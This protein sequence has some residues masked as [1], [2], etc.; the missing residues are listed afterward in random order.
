[1]VKISGAVSHCSGALITRRHVLTAAHCFCKGETPMLDCPVE[2]VG[3][4]KPVPNAQ[5]IV[6]KVGSLN[7]RLAKSVAVASAVVHPGYQSKVQPTHHDIAMMTLA[8]EV[9]LELGKVT[10][11]ATSKCD[12]INYFLNLLP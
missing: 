4:V 10:L 11:L 5:G 7:S 12:M 8:T 3:K 2:A 1:M 9:E 6:A